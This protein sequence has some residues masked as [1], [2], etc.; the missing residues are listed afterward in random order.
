VTYPVWNFTRNIFG[1]YTFSSRPRRL[2]GICKKLIWG[3]L[4][5][6]GAIITGGG[7]GIFSMLFLTPRQDFHQSPAVTPKMQGPV[8]LPPGL[9]SSSTL[10]SSFLHQPC[11]IWISVRFTKSQIPSGKALITWWRKLCGCTNF[12]VVSYHFEKVERRSWRNHTVFVIVITLHILAAPYSRRSSLK[13]AHNKKHTL[14]KWFALWT[15]IQIRTFW[16][17]RIIHYHYRLNESICG[18]IL[19]IHSLWGVCFLLWANFNWIWYSIVRFVLLYRELTPVVFVFKFVP[20]D[21][22]LQQVQIYEMEEFEGFLTCKM[23]HSTIF[24]RSFSTSQIDYRALWEH[25]SSIV[26]STYR[27]L[28]WRLLLIAV[29]SCSSINST[30]NAYPI[31]KNLYIITASRSHI[32]LL[33]IYKCKKVFA[34]RTFYIV[35]RRCLVELWKRNFRRESVRETQ[36]NHSRSSGSRQPYPRPSYGVNWPP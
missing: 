16:I 27:N 30:I 10:S 36:E 28:K 12:F 13:F 34:A 33:R 9:S 15:E 19:R 24:F 4:R 18:V 1:L 23:I 32:E 8:F 11:Q 29:I 25:S 22:L 5:G 17:I 3:R 6:H 35:S 20:N 14:N 7:G 21:I 31:H 2:P 26:Q